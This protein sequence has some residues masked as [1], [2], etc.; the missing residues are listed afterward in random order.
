M[1]I[2][3][4]TQSL[5]RAKKELWRLFSR[6]IRYRDCLKTTGTLDRGKCITCGKEFK[7]KK[8]QAG[9]FIPGRNNAVLYNE[10]HVHAQCWQCNAPTALGGKNG[11]PFV[12][13]RKIIEIY[14]KNSDELFEQESQQIVQY[15][16]FQILDM[17]EEYKTK[18]IELGG[19]IK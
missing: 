6:Y 7:F 3:H 4:K 8:L 13:R 14:G 10:R 15:K 9:H 12:Y 18:I 16:V 19:S 11:N 2:K 5:S 1:A 17:Q